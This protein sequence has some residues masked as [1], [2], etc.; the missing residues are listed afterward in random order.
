VIVPLALLLIGP[1]A[2]AVVAGAVGDLPY[3]R[4]IAGAVFA[5]T[6]LAGAAYGL[7]RAVS[8]AGVAWR[9]FTLDPWRGLL[10]CGAAFAIAVAVIGDDES[11]AASGRQAAIF[12]AGAALM[13]PLVVPGVHL[14]AV[15]LVAGTIGYGVAAFAVAPDGASSLRAARST[16]AL[17]VSDGIALAALG[18]SLGRGVAL[19]VHPSTTMAALLLAAAAI[20]LGLAPVAGPAA[21]ATRAD[22]ALSLLWHGPVRAQ[23]FL[24]ALMAIG[25]GRNLAHAA[26]ALAAFSLATSAYAIVRR[27]EAQGLT[28]FAT[29]VALLGFGVG[30]A[31]ATWGGVLALAGAFAAF[32]AWQT[33]AKGSPIA[34]SFL[35]AIPAGAV[36]PG[37]ALVAGSTLAASTTRPWFAALAVPLVAAA[38]ATIPSLWQPRGSAAGATHGRSFGFATSSIGLAAALAIAAVPVRAASGLGVPVAATLGTGRLLSIGG[39]PGISAVLAVVIVAV[40][41]VAFIAAPIAARPA[42][43]PADGAPADRDTA[44][45]VS[46]RPGLF[47]WWAVAPDGPVVLGER[48]METTR[49]WAIAAAILIALSAGLALRVYV[50]AAGRGFL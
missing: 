29:G 5:A 11:P 16:L 45:L 1:I 15:G 14:L 34:R 18:A 44:E 50:V 21:D 10:A 22:R 19:P 33:N 49:R 28:S 30:G 9:G 24:L 42:I 2:G 35:A 41:A 36:L 32:P 43:G 6:M 47:A 46:D 23:G 8:H 17:A 25:S 7:Q 40:A 3:A 39:D 48:A 37:V 4:R 20:R 38:A 13:V 12:A 27:D 26:A 31:T